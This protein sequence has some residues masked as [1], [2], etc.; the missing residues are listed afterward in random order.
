MEEKSGCGYINRTA[1]TLAGDGGGGG[2]GT[3]R[4]GGVGERG[5]W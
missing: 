5:G 4:C 2:V 3:G 1:V